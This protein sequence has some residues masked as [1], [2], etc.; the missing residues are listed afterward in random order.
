MK[1]LKYCKNYQNVTQRHEV[2]K[3]SWKNGADRLAGRRVATN[4]QFVKKT[5]SVKH[6]K[7]TC[8]KTRYAC[9]QFTCYVPIKPSWEA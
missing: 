8:N 3:C 4:L 6:N 5:V 1:S 9:R 2:S 7:V